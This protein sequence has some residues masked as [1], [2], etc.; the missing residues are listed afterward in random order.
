MS[1]EQE[2]EVLARQE[3]EFQEA[4]RWEV[5]RKC[6]DTNEVTWDEEENVAREEQE[7]NQPPT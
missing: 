2:V 4:F 3:E 5:K 1:A 7:R 6:S